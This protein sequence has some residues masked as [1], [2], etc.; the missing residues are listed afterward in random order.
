MKSDSQKPII[1][2]LATPIG[3][4]GDITKRAE[5]TLRNCDLIAAEDT[6]VTLKLLSLLGIKGK[7]LISYHDKTEH[8]KALPL[9]E[10]VEEEELSLVLVS[11]AG[12]PL[13]SDPGYHL[14]HE[15]HK[16]GIKVSPVPGPSSLTS[17]VSCS[18]LPSSKLYFT[19]FLPKKDNL[20]KKEMRSWQNLE[21]S[22]VFFE[23]AL[24]LTSTLEM[25]QEEYPDSKI[26]L[27][28]EL[29]K[30]HE[31][32]FTASFK[33]VLDFVQNSLTLKGEF[34]LMLSLGETKKALTQE[35]KETLVRQALENHPKAKSKELANLLKEEGISSKE[36]Y[37]LILREKERK[38]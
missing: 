21:A 5:E 31:T 26:C 2:V 15:A 10:R 1:F 18:G 32:I 6:R 3:N 33:E 20:R 4:L 28:K 14:I 37:D 29:T 23:T 24:R 16:K 27:G 35:N 30:L 13:I 34:V 11:D 19:G 25:I 7:E 12:T 36:A 22:I 9:L 38:S 17:L 8:K